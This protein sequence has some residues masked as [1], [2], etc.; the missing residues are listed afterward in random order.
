M[1]AALINVPAKAKRGDVIEIRTLTS[2]IMETGFRHTAAGDLVPRDIITSF[3]C[4]YNGTEIFRADLYPAIAANPY[5]SF[6]AVAKESGKF[7]FEWI[8]D[9]GYS[10]TASASI[11]VE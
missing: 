5:L 2:H 9:N 1:A 7:E 4:R 8:G 3:T 11:I 6:Y 10:S